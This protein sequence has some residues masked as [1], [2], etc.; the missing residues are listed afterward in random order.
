MIQYQQSKYRHLRSMIHA[1]Q[2]AQALLTMNYI[3]SQFNAQNELE[4]RINPYL[5][6]AKQNGIDLSDDQIKDQFIQQIH[7]M[8]QND[9]LQIENFNQGGIIA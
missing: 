8:I 6:I 3:Q 1:D 5:E 9:A 2:G 7:Q 4:A